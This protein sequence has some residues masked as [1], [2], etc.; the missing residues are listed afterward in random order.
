MECVK[1]SKITEVHVIL[2]STLSCIGPQLHCYR[3]TELPTKLCAA[4]R[5]GAPYQCSLVFPLQHEV[6]VAAPDRAATL[7]GPWCR[8]TAR[9]PIRMLLD[10]GASIGPAARVCQKSSGSAVHLC[11]ASPSLVTCDRQCR[12][13]GSTDIAQF[14]GRRFGAHH[15]FP[16]LA[17]LLAARRLHRRLTDQRFLNHEHPVA[18][19]EALD[20]VVV[21]QAPGIR[22][23]APLIEWR[24][25]P[26]EGPVECD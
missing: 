24:R 2:H 20:R 7:A 21:R 10:N 11:F 6:H 4:D 12:C 23:R 15:S 25:A 22:T 3:F 1:L 17:H 16:W 8:R 9:A 19:S 26:H 5:Q 18:P 13:T 14:C